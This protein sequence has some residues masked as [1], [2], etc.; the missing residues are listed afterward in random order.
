M[1]VNMIESMIYLEDY[2][3]AMHY[4]EEMVQQIEKKGA[5]SSN[6]HQPFWVMARIYRAT[7]DKGEAYTL[8]NKAIELIQQRIDS[9]Q[10]EKQVTAISFQ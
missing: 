6:K 3:Q 4:A 5:S 10:A 2:E 9:L 7:G 8:L 1:C